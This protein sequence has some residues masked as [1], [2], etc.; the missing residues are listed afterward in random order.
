MPTHTHTHTLHRLT[1]RAAS[2]RGEFHLYIVFAL[3]IKCDVSVFGSVEQSGL[4]LLLVLAE[5][6]GSIA[7]ENI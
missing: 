6:P 5:T 1:A 3:P 7:E 2:D 4:G